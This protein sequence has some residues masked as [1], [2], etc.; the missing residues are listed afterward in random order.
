MTILIMETFAL[1]HFKC[2]FIAND[3]C[4]SKGSTSR[5]ALIKLWERMQ[6]LRCEA[7]LEVS[8]VSSW[9]S[10]ASLEEPLE[11][12]SLLGLRIFL[13]LHQVTQVLP[14]SLI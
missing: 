7:Y 8:F 1:L 10:R 13:L 2:K 14:N 12:W 9:L 4:Q 5:L 11:V 6:I 3:W